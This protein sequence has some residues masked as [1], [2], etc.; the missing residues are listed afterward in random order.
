MQ[1]VLLGAKD[2]RT[3]QEEEDEGACPLTL[4]CWFIVI[5][6]EGNDD[7]PPSMFCGVFAWQPSRSVAF[8]WE[9]KQLFSSH[10]DFA[11]RD[12]ARIDHVG[13]AALQ[14]SSIATSS[15]Q[16]HVVGRVPCIVDGVIDSRDGGMAKPNDGREQRFNIRGLQLHLEN[17][18]MLITV[19]CLAILSAARADISFLITSTRGIQ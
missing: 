5:D 14:L 8:S 4:G 16:S 17:E 19:E 10:R 15:G 13:V 6:I 9:D 18:Q 12:C 11:Y 2:Q 7:R 1:V 3:L